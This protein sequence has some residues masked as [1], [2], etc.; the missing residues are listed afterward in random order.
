MPYS[1]VGTCPQHRPLHTVSSMGKFSGPTAGPTGA[2]SWKYLSPLGPL[3]APQVLPVLKVPESSGPTAGPTGTFS[4]VSAHLGSILPAYSW[5]EAPHLLAFFSPCR[6]MQPAF[7]LQMWLYFC[8]SHTVSSCLWYLHGRFTLCCMYYGL[9][10]TCTS[11]MVFY[12]AENS[13]HT[14]TLLTG[15]ATCACWTSCSCYIK[16]HAYHI[17]TPKPSK[18]TSPGKAGATYGLSFLLKAF[19]A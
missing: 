11:I 18:Q 6:P 10:N 16:L 12:A 8:M 7:W 9:W 1:T 17:S 2:S 3:L 15:I 14:Q 13:Q 4:A 5:A 19:Q